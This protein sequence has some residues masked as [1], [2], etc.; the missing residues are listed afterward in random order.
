MRQIAINRMAIVIVDGSQSQDLT[1]ALTQN[2]FPV[3]MLDAVGGFLHEAMVTFFVGLP[4]N[5][6]PRFFSLVR[7]YCPSRTRYVSM[8]V[9]LALTPGYPMMI[10]ARLGGATVFVLPV[11]R[12]AQF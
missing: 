3:T 11:E 7:E 9:E 8:G 1:H 12:F 10:E 5:K 6:L 2:D 4:H